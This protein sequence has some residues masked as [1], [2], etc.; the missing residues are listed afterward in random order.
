MNVLNKTIK[1]NAKER[2]DYWLSLAEKLEEIEEYPCLL[3]D[4]QDDYLQNG[5]YHECYGFYEDSDLEMFLI[6]YKINIVSKE[7]NICI[8]EC[9]GE[10]Y[11]IEV[12]DIINRHGDDLPDETI[13]R[14]NTLTEI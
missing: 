6:G 3:E 5:V 4:V 1:L 11:R 9:E 8:L 2:V 14:L 10:K 13:F 12:L 7:N